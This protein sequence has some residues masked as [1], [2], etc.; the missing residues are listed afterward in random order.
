MGAMLEAY[1]RIE[2]EW[3]DIADKSFNGGFPKSAYVGACALICVVHDNK[4]YV[5]NAGDSKAV[6][7]RLNEAGDAIE[8]VKISKTFNA[9][10]K[11]EQERLRN[12]FPS[13]KD[14]VVCK[15]GGAG[16]C[17]VKGGLMP[18]RALGDLRLKYPEF[19]FHNYPRDHGYR[20]P[21]PKANYSGSYINPVPDV[22][23]FDLTEKDRFV[24]LAS[25]GLWDEFNRKVSAE[26]ATE[27]MKGDK[28]LNGKN[29][30]LALINKSLQHAAE[31]RGISREFLSRVPP[32][33]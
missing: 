23:V 7:L 6:L 8:R 30:N 18:T 31:K 14:I 21:I 13:E 16:A 11:Y 1:N 26:V 5:A 15:R 25:D 24:V 33:R 3:K 12:A 32:G 4:L 27:I 2:H 28:E 10:K 17:Y 20:P 19:N 22:Q 9:N 29:L